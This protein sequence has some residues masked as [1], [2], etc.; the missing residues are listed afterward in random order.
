MLWIQFSLFQVKDFHEFYFLFLDSNSTSTSSSALLD[1]GF[2]G[3]AATPK[4]TNTATAE[5]TGNSLLDEQFK[6]LGRFPY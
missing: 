4:S 3:D 6:L 1:L 2:D 5:T